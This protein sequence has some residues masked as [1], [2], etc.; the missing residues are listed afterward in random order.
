MRRFE[1]RTI[2]ITGAGS[3]IGKATALRFGSEGGRVYCADIDGA[4]AERTATE[5]REAGGEAADTRCDVS[6]PA[7]VA[8]TVDGAVER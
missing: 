6:D 7:A 5:I 8:R 1:G 4:A 2:L 3:G